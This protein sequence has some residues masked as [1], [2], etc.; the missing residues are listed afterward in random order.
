MRVRPTA[1]VVLFACSFAAC[2][3][4]LP[5]VPIPDSGADAGELIEDSG[6]ADAG[7]S[8]LG[9]EDAAAL[10]ASSTDAFVLDASPAD[11][12]FPD[13]SVV[14]AGSSFPFVVSNF[15]PNIVEPAKPNTTLDCGTST[16]TYDSANDTAM[17]SGWC[18]GQTPPTP[19]VQIAGTDQE[20]VVLAFGSL[21][22][23]QGSRLRLAGDRP[24]ILAVYGSA[25]IAGEID[26]TGS[27]STPGPGGGDVFHCGNGAGEAGS[28]A[29]ASFARG[30][31][32]G[33][34]FGS[35]GRSGGVGV[36]SGLAGE[37]G[38]TNGN[39]SLIPLR[40]GCSGGNGARPNPQLPTPL[41]G[42]GGGAVQLSVSDLLE[43][44]GTISAS[45]GGGAGGGIRSGGG[46][47]GA[48]GA[49]L[50]EAGSLQVG[51]A[52][53]VTA[54]GGGGGEG[55][56]AQGP[57]VSDPGN[58]GAKRSA[59]SASG[60]SGESNSGGDG[61]NGGAL[62]QDAQIGASGQRCNNCQ[63]NQGGGGGG[64]GGGRGRIRLRAH[65]QCTIANTQ[66]ISPSPILNNCP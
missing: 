20:V 11:V 1:L 51:N 17:F 23:A 37:G 40:G 49:V 64:G 22:I 9:F 7:I 32:G 8:D 55:G 33:G 62:F 60:G 27:G 65:A 38:T 15:D 36:F 14:D 4:S 56:S 43:V 2:T 66:S 5:V 6:A 42:G 13:V 39:D 58:D 10:D 48:G 19:S 46:G 29:V 34:G 53:F 54:N 18:S 61:G 12:S 44:N 24:I 45:G 50:L 21:N 59:M 28:S 31:G 47:G 57:G 63:V 3:F 35:M 41:G 30:G 25:N 52:A 26:A 16:F